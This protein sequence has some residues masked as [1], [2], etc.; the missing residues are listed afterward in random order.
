MSYIPQELEVSSSQ[1]WRSAE[2]VSKQPL[3]G[4]MQS[5][6]RKMTPF[7]KWR[8]HG[9]HYWTTIAPPSAL[10]NLIGTKVSIKTLHACLGHLSWSLLQKLTKNIDPAQKRVLSTFEGCLLGKSSQHKFLATTH[11][12]TEPFILV[13]MCYKYWLSNH[14]SDQISDKNIRFY[15]QRY[16][17]RFT[18]QTQLEE[19]PR[20]TLNKS[21][22]EHTT[23]LT[24]EAHISSFG[25]RTHTSAWSGDWTPTPRPRTSEIHS[26]CY[27]HSSPWLHL[28]AIPG[29]PHTAENRYMN[30]ED[31]SPDIKNIFPLSHPSRLIPVAHI[32]FHS[33]CPHDSYTYK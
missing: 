12:Q 14:Y 5:L 32:P 19:H 15:S 30:S 22:T 16:P 7:L 33:T 17:R 28:P 20:H 18:L 21:Q 10:V 26:L 9:N 4:I 25:P 8:V 23:E 11:Q 6:W 29:I 24:I 2:K 1:F 27:Q 3:P 13:H 31:H